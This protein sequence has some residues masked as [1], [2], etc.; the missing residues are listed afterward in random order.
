DEMEMNMRLIG[1]AK[2]SDLH[3]GMVDTR[4]LSLHSVNS[5][6][7]TLGLNVY[8]PLS[9]PKEKANL[10]PPREKSKL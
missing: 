1:A 4:A 3:P 6:Y 5:P 8:D 9:G 10:P 7:D 2:V